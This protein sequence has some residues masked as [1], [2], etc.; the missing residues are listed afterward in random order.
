MRTAFFLDVALHYTDFV[1]ELLDVCAISAYLCVMSVICWMWWDVYLQFGAFPQRRWLNSVTHIT[2]N[3][4]VFIWNIGSLCV[5]YGFG[6][7]K[8]ANH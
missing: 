3:I 7:Q 5:F 6:L 2:A 8:A 4:L 1:F